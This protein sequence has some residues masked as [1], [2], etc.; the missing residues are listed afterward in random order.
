MQ[1]WKRWLYIL[2]A[3]IVFICAFY[4]LFSFRCLDFIV[5][6][7]WFKSLG[8]EFYYL[9]RFSYKYLIFS[10]V[11][12]AFFVIF[13]IN[14]SIAVKFIKKSVLS[15]PNKDVDSDK[16]PSKIFTVFQSGTRKI[17]IILS[18][19][20]AFVIAM[21]FYEKWEKALLLFFGS[22]V[23]VSDV[24]FGKDISFYLFYFPIFKLIQVRVFV[25]FLILLLTLVMTYWILKRFTAKNAIKFPKGA[26]IHLAIVILI[27]TLIYACKFVLECYGYLFSSNHQPLFFGPGFIETWFYIP[28]IWASLFLFILLSIA[29]TFFFFK[30]KGL[31]LLILSIVLFMVSIW[32]QN[33]SFIPNMINKYYVKPN[34]MAREKPYIKAG[35]NAALSAYK[36]NDVETV[37]YKINE[38]L[39]ININEDITNQLR[40]IPVWDREL[41]EGVYQQLQGIKP[42]YTFPSVD[43][44][45]Y[46]VS[47]KYQQV[48]LA[49]RELNIGE[50]PDYAKNWP[51]IHLQYT[52]GYGV[53]MTPAAQGGDEAMT[54]FLHDF[55]ITSQYDLSV[56]KPGIYYGQEK[57][58]YV[59]CSN[60]GG[61]IDH[62]T[63]EANAVVNYNGAGGVKLSSIFHRL[64]FSLYFK[65][66]KILLT[67]ELTEKS[68]I[69]FHR[70]I[71]ERITKI[72]PYLLLD[73]DPYLVAVKD[74]LFWIQD[75]YTVSDTYPN[76]P[77][78]KNSFN[79][80]RNS[81]K[82]VVD[83]YNGS[84]TFYKSSDDDPIIKAYANIYPEIFKEL[85]DFPEA[86]KN[87]IR[88]PK[89]LFS[90]QM[91]I[92]AKYHQ[93]NPEYFYRQE[94]I[95]EITKGLSAQNSE[96]MQPYYLTL[97]LDANDEDLDYGGSE[98]F[99]LVPMSPMGRDNLRSL[100]IAKC[101]GENYGKIV[102]YSFPQKKQVYG[103]SQ[104]SALIDQDT[105]ISQQLTLWD[106][107]GSRVVRGNMIIF[108]V[109]NLIYYIQPVYLISASRLKIPELKRIIVSQGELVAM[110]SSIEEAFIVLESRLKKRR[111][112]QQKR[113]FSTKKSGKKVKIKKNEPENNKNSKDSD[114]EVKKDVALPEEERDVQAV[115]KP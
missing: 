78:M 56:N 57:Y 1:H 33:V 14:F 65:N 90:L 10:S 20:M 9:K 13:F 40:N 47:G 51:N 75:A 54:W 68:R 114:F 49:A 52:H 91:E 37:K 16:K 112:L 93:K 11:I 79:Y 26:N 80:I 105:E 113:H 84:I 98:F 66:K 69:L 81:V 19:A 38:N 46:V 60:K 100:C 6:F 44:G 95:W 21:P 59:I 96:H 111:A 55:P 8:F 97:N 23:G 17:F 4:L 27:T 109:D 41:L 74:G 30:K 88:Y 24:V 34:E 102:V 7:L 18:F 42:Y 108:P 35:I 89:D 86:L 87:H 22:G 82:I 76:S 29:G 85:K 12:I 99:L 115:T 72:V 63:D 101:D 61:E 64:I 106:Q 94:D 71:I 92:Y 70:N 110:E 39:N 31:K 5:D 45:R 62:P 2:G 43:V 32:L 25:I 77:Y 103:P 15:L 58:D 28:L 48:Y 50:L 107:K 67:S 53:V 104:I 3:A 73:S 36:L 83:A